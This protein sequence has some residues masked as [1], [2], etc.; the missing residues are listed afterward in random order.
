MWS[1]LLDGT[2]GDSTAYRH[3][4]DVFCAIFVELLRLL[5]DVLL[6][7]ALLTRCMRC[8]RWL[9]L[10]WLG[11]MYISRMAGSLDDSH[12][13]ILLKFTLLVLLGCGIQLSSLT[14]RYAIFQHSV[15]EVHN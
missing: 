7:A 8:M 2:V 4:C 6:L 1:D 13:G 11:F 10:W 14:L 12:L 9:V 15:P 5:I 3:V